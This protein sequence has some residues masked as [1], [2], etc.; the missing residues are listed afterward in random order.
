MSAEPSGAVLN[1]PPGIDVYS[2]KIDAGVIISGEAHV[3]P[4]SNPYTISLSH[5]PQLNS[6]STVIIPGFT[7]VTGLPSSNQFLVNYS[8]TGAGS[9]MFSAFNGGNAITA[10]FTTAGDNIVAEWFNSLQTSVV[11]IENFI[12]S[13]LGIS[14][15]YVPVT[16]A[17]VNGTITL[18]GGNLLTATSGTN[19]IGNSTAPFAHMYANSVHT[20]N[21]VSVNG[22]DSIRL[23]ASI[24]VSG[25]TTAQLVSDNNVTV[26]GNNTVTIVAKNSGVSIISDAGGVTVAGH[27]VPSASSTFDLGSSS[28]RWRK[29][30]ADE[31]SITSGP[32]VRTT[33]DTMTGELIM[34]TGASLLTDNISNASS[35]LNITSAANINLN[36]SSV[37][38]ITSNNTDFNGVLSTNAFGIVANSSIVPFA[39]STYDLG[40]SSNHFANLY[41]DNIEGAVASGM[42]VRISGDTMT[43]DLT[44]GFGSSINVET[45]NSL[46]PSGGMTVNAGEFNVNATNNIRFAISPS[47]VQKMEIG[48]SNIYVNTDV[49][50]AESGVYD[51]GSPTLHYRAV[52]ADNIYMGAVG[53]GVILDG[54]ILGNVTVTGDMSF[55]PGSSISN[56]SSGTIDIGSPSE[57]FGT[58]YATSIVTAE[59]TG[60]FISKFGDTMLGVLN[61]GTGSS[62]TASGSGINNIGSPSNPMGMIFAT[63]IVS[64]G[65]DDMYVNVTGDL[66]TGA[67]TLPELLSTGTLDISALGIVTM[68]GS[69]IVQ[70]A[71]QVNITSLTG[72]VIID[73][74]TEMQ[75]LVN[76]APTLVLNNSGT[77]SYFNITPDSSGTHSLGTPDKPW[78]AIYANFIVPVGVSGTGSFVLKIGDSMSGDLTF[79]SGVGITLAQSGTS[80]IG[81]PSNPLNA[82]YADNLYI[83]GA[84][85]FVHVTGDTMTGDLTMSSAAL[86][87][88]FISGTN[89]YSGLVISASSGVGSYTNIDAKY[90]GTALNYYQ[91]GVPH[92]GYVS[93]GATDGL[94]PDIVLYSFTGGG[95]SAYRQTINSSSVSFTGGSFA[96]FDVYHGSVGVGNHFSIDTNGLMLENM[97]AG[98]SLTVTSSSTVGIRISG[99][100]TT[101]TSGNY[102][103]GT[104]ALPFSGAYFQNING[105]PATV[106]VYNE[107]PPEFVDGLT[108]TF[109]TTY[110]MVTGTQ[111]VYRG[112]LRMTPGVSNDYQ[113]SG[114]MVTFAVAPPTGTNILIDYERLAF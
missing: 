106:Q 94:D 4:V 87:T 100:I 112:G 66:M 60:N 79:L 43:G 90:T 25:N 48:L 53:S 64:P 101:A 77:E 21:I 86:R 109:T 85:A 63:G 93:I 95:G 102:S 51:L 71:E 23:G 47:G 30:W 58:I 83:G 34:S 65:L 14:G 98:N 70:S 28:N 105:Q 27:T 59:S 13:G 29:V 104:A 19:Q 73:A 54:A 3:V 62:I 76:S 8:G 31:V 15:N 103:I 20:N 113:A 18:S 88:A 16:G 52:Y 81:S 38:T 72:P 89:N 45:V 24:V 36:S 49:L 33:G 50:P 9:V 7:E 84:G 75:M 5:V 68:T 108:N 110:P 97:T 107:I 42:F 6:P 46:V 61:L 91:A 10:T 40:S 22:N 99:N 39:P 1:F 82:L 37:L 11:S 12:V 55:G 67:L 69:Q 96:S 26:S 17:T 2:T 44:M 41:V 56:T 92:Y 111:R 32:F 114:N 35:D 74:N 80:D 57:P 78:D